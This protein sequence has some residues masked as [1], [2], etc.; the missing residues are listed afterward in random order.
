[1]EQDVYNLPAADVPSAAE[2][3]KAIIACQPALRSKGGWS[4]PKEMLKAHYY[5]PDRTVTAGELALHGSVALASFKAANLTYGK[6]AKALCEYFDRS[7]K[8]KLAILVKFSGGVPGDELVRW[9]MLPQV[10]AALEELGWV[11]AGRAEVSSR[12]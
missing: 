2:Y 12:G 11:D 10:A 1:M 5:A 6:Y 9:T 7:P 3:K 4:V 8:F